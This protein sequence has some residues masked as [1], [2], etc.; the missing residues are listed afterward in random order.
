MADRTTETIP[1]ARAAHGGAADRGRLVDHF[2]RVYT[3]IAGLAITEACRHLLPFAF[4]SWPGASFWMFCTF[5]VTIVPIFQGGDRSL[6][7]KYL[8]NPPTGPASRW[9][10]IWDVY[11]LLVTALL[12]VCT[13]ESIP[14]LP[15]APAADP[16]NFYY[17]MAIVLVFDAVALAVDWLK[18]PAPQELRP[19]GLWIVLNAIVGVICFI[20][21]VSLSHAG[22]TMAPSLVA[23]GVFIVA[24]ARTI[25]DYAKSGRF[26]FPR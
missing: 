1:A 26:M 11:V 15:P 6:D 3:I 16:A 13:A 8:Y 17:W 25:L 18:S 10:Y 12:F 23:F 7:I 5:F 2:K 4:D 9:L 22:V 24:L 19:Y 20:A 14:Q 21:A